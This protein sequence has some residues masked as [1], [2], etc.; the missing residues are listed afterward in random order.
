MFTLLK[1][2][3]IG[4]FELSTI[5]LEKYLKYVDIYKNL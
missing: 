3:K 5:N 4:T 2:M 1:S